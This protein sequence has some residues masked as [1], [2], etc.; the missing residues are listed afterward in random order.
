M[1]FSDGKFTTISFF[2]TIATIWSGF[3]FKKVGHEIFSLTIID[4]EH[5]LDS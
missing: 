1:I 4:G 2:V 3:T 5:A